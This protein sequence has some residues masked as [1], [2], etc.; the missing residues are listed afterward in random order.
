MHFLMFEDTIV[1][2]LQKKYNAESF[3]LTLTVMLYLFFT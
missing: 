2:S 1:D 3:V